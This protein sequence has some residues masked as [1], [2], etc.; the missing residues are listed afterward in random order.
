MH[1]L[2]RKFKK[3]TN[4]HRYIDIVILGYFTKE[5]NICRNSICVIGSTFTK[6]RAS[7]SL[8]E[9]S[10]IKTRCNFNPIYVIA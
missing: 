2:V 5:L 9:T 7:V 8:E 4:G 3:K 1:F 6:R 10:L